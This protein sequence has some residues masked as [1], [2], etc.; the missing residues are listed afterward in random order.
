M[1]LGNI[2]AYTAPGGSFPEFVSVNNAGGGV[3]IVVRSIKAPD[4]KAGD[5][6]AI[7]LSYDEFTNLLRAGNAFFA[8][9]KNVQEVKQGA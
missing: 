3:S 7:V 5:T 2:Y 6:A 9:S 4:G 1:S 8:K